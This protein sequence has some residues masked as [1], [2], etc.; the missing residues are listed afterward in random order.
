M[1]DNSTAYKY[2]ITS[3]IGTCIAEVATLPICTLKTNYQT[4]NGTTIG[5]TFRHIW[6]N[7]GI[8]GFYNS[9][10]WAISSQILSTATKYTLYREI[11]HIVPNKFI[12]GGIAGFFGSLLT[13]PFDV[14]K[15]HYQKQIPFLPE[16]QK[17]GSRLFYRGYSKSLTKAVVGSTL[18]LPLFD[19]FNENFRNNSYIHTVTSNETII[20]SMAAMSSSIISTTIMQPVDYMKT[21]HVLNINYKHMIGNFSLYFRG[22]SLNLARVVPHFVITMTSIK[23]IE[24]HF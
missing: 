15:M 20:T 18:F 24:S 13:H 19:K 7:Y 23:I 3:A 2:A 1:Y 17:E 14:L 21:R 22:L 10:G 4:V 9:S 12:S 8:K 6:S 16:L 5:G 11:E